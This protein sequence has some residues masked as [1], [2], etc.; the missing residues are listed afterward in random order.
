MS[1]AIISVKQVS[2]Q[3][4]RYDRPVDRL[5]EV[6]LPGKSRANQFWA[7]RD[8]DFEVKRGETVG[9]IGQNGS[10]KST[11]LQI[12]AGTL[13][14]TIGEVAVQGRISALLELGS[15]FNPEF[16]GR[17][18]VFFN[19]RILGLT[20]TEIE[21]KFDDIAAFA[22]I[23]DF[24][25]QP[26][27]TY[28]S[29]MFVRL[30]FSVAVN[31]DPDIL[32]VDEALAVGDIVFQ[33]RCMKRMRDLMDS[34]ITTLF[35]SHDANAVR[36]LCSRA[37]LLHKGQVLNVGQP[38]NMMNQYV[39]LMTDL[40]VARESRLL[41][42]QTTSPEPVA[43][44]TTTDDFSRVRRG[45][46]TMR[47]TQVAIVDEWGETA[48]DLPTVTFDQWATVRVS[49]EA[50]VAVAEYIV[51][52]FVCDKNG[53]EVLGTNTEEELLELRPLQVGD[54]ATI[55][56]RFKVPLRPGGYSLTVACTQNKLGVTSDWIENVLVFQVIPSTNGKQVHA[57]IY[58]P[59]E[60]QVAYAQLRS[61]AS[62]LSN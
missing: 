20:P 55:D 13:Q 22:D 43:D 18:N 11:L 37:I 5:K 54:R 15:G 28:S 14:P 30:A 60:A 39:K 46:Q 10:G 57:L 17:Q 16:T 24:M 38:T 7:L 44:E 32:I 29:G 50:Q 6:L 61:P 35:V 49:V 41:E 53:V 21:A 19:G 12:I 33:H 48:D 36:T 27:K 8:V 26:V 58:H 9:I 42:A 4:Q 45:D 59:V 25:D 3:F 23:G 2:K 40:E 52:F 31:I 1:N 34:G 51:G 62:E 56:F 47:I